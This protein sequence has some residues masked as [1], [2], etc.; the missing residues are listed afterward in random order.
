MK[1]LPNKDGLGVVIFGITILI[2]F[3][4]FLTP[5][6]WIPFLLYLGMGIYL[7]REHR[8]ELK[9]YKH[10]PKYF[11]TIIY[12]HYKKLIEK[13]KKSKLMKIVGD[14]A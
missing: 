10:K 14:K 13:A 5:Y 9:K 8:K 2:S 11:F 1:K 6:P 4:M 7:Y 3:V 12:L